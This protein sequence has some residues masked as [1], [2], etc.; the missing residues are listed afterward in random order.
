MHATMG[1]MP[2]LLLVFT[3]GCAVWMDCRQRRIPNRLIV[4]SLILGLLWQLL[5][6]EGVWSFDVDAPGATGLFGFLIGAGGL[7][8]ALLPLHLMRVMGGGDVK[9][10]AV[11]GGLCGASAAH[12]EHLPGI[13]LAVLVA[14]GL[15]AVV[16]MMALGISTPVMTSVLRLASAP[17]ARRDGRGEPHVTADRMPYAV[18]IAL[19]T[20]GYLTARVMRWVA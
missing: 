8:L 1:L 16:R 6:P 5:G 4:G 9:L 15:L 19:G 18:A 10:L 11:V 2:W 12:W 3:L 13:V 17:F 20:L 7:L 14:G